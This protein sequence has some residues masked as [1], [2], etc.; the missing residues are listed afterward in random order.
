MNH[1]LDQL[2]SEK[3]FHYIQ[4][5]I[6]VMNESREIVKANQPAER[7]LGWKVVVCVSYL[8]YCQE[9]EIK[10]VDDR[11]YYIDNKGKI[12]YFSSEMPTFGDYLVDVQMSNV[13]IYHEQQTNEKYYLLVLRDQTLKKK[14]E[15]A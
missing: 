1:E 14:E 4:D 10:E 9:S 12:L 11:V 3:L 5:G 2:F 13:L 8:S 6:I 15:E 7:I